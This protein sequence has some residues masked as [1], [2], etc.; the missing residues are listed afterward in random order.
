MG[1]WHARGLAINQVVLVEQF[2]HVLAMIE[3][4]SAHNAVPGVVHA[5]YFRRFSLFLDAKP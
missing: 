1:P 2:T 4:D 5:I 3:G